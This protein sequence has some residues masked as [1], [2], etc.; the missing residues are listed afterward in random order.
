MS[1]FFSHYPKVAYNITGEK[2]PTK[3]RVAVDIMNR[4]KIK[5]LFNFYHILYQKMKDRM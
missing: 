4:T 3:L 5:G 1:E 2:E